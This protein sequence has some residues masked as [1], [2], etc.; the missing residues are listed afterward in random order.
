MSSVQENILS[1]YIFPYLELYYYNHWLYTGLYVSSTTASLLVII[2][3]I[4][5]SVTYLVIARNN[6]L[7]KLANTNNI[8][9]SIIKDLSEN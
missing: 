9:G 5:D 8:I 1:Y 6:N 2:I 4:E 3:F 7:V